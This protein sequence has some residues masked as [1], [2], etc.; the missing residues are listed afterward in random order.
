ML[1]HQPQKHSD[2]DWIGI[3]WVSPDGEYLLY[4][5]VDEQSSNLMLVEN[6]R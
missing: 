6:W 1:I 4:P 5:Q 3:L 2:W